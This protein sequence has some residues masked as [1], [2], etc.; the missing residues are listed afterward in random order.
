VGS[1]ADTALARDPLQ[2][3]RL[4]QRARQVRAQQVRSVYLQSPVTTTGSLLTGLALVAVMWNAVPR[5]ILLGW[6]AVMVVHQIVR[7]RHYRG[8]VAASAAEQ[9]SDKWGRLYVIAA[10][11]AGC[12]WGSAGFLM[13]VPDSIAHQA[14]LSLVLYG[15]VTVSMAA[16]SAYAPA[17]NILVPLTLAPLIVRA[18]LEPG[19]AHIYLA[20]PAALVLGTALA[21]GRN[22]NRLFTATLTKRFENMDLIEEL[23]RQ[24][25]IAEQARIAAEAANRSKTQFFASASHDLR[26]PLHAIG[27][28]AAALG[29]KT[30]DP[31]VRGIA[32]S[33]TASVDALDSLFNALLDISKIDAGVLQ[34]SFVTFPINEVLDRLR[35]DFAPQAREKG[36]ELRVVPSKAYVYSDP[37][38]MERIPRNLISNAIRYTE[39]GGIVVGCRRRGGALR[40]EVWDTGIGIPADQRERVFDEFYQIAKSGSHR[41]RGT[42]LGL[43]IVKRLCQMF[44]YP[45]SFASVAGRGTVFRFEV[46]LAAAPREAPVL[47]APAA[48]A[49]EDLAGRLIVVI[50]DDTEIVEGMKL[51]LDGWRASVLAATSVDDAVA[52]V[53]EHEEV[54]DLIIADYQL[55][56]ATTG[57]QAI[58][59]LRRTLDPEIP[60]IV[61]TGS[62]LAERVEEAR[63]QRCELALK[64]VV[65]EKLR[66]LID[67]NLRPR[68]AP[69]RR[70]GE[71][72]ATS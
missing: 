63:A 65:P 68:V 30:T 25:A 42:G 29:E 12:L 11:I 36:L 15:I 59:R 40:I 13:Y 53:E 66:V 67:R 52:L 39:S 35:A 18:L 17:F 27:L 70:P 69:P 1:A 60:A 31:E 37:L 26:Q 19:A 62:N 2:A 32:A 22:V 72:G 57:L 55:A 7:I 46:P 64:P 14:F 49:T 10:A 9:A 47:A 50:D 28:F 3:K 6:L 33:I 16:L 21:L 61:L 43:A 56:D 58:A 8:F 20:V 51:L 54:P 44:G 38:L 5:A 24:K 45:I 23:S 41:T 34:P 48:R 71:Q 4:E